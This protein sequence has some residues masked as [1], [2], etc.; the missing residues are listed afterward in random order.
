[1]NVWEEVWDEYPPEPRGFESRRRRVVGPAEELGGSRR[2]GASV[3]ELPPGVTQ[4]PYHFQHAQE[5]LLVVLRGTPTLRTPAG[6]R[7]LEE[8]E[9]VFC[10]T[11]PRGAHQVINRTSETVRYL[12]VS[13]LADAE[14]VEYPDSGKV[15]ASSRGPSTRGERLSA[16][17]RFGDAVG[18][19][20]G[21]SPR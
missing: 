6:E 2:L 19:Y 7:T 13:N 10:P 18:Y 5:E 17:F 16:M 3:W 15:L 4:S 8:G 11:G 14:V 12:W 20:D 1:V 21:E 9:I